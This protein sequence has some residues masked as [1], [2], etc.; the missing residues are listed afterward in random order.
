MST[1]ELDVR[2][3][4]IVWLLKDDWPRW[5]ALDPNFQPDFDHWRRRIEAAID[6]LESTGTR[7]EPIIVDPDRFDKWRRENG[8][9][10]NAGSRAVYAAWLLAQRDEAGHAA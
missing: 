2:G 4:A 5:L 1:Q 3:I 8:H 10:M 6:Q 7:C 9:P